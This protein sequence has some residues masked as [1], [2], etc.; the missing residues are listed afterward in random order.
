MFF[1]SIHL[2]RFFIAWKIY[3]VLYLMRWRFNLLSVLGICFSGSPPSSTG[4]ASGLVPPC[5]FE[6]IPC[7]SFPSIPLLLFQRGEPWSRYGIIILGVMTFTLFPYLEGQDWCWGT[8]APVSYA[9]EDKS[10]KFGHHPY[11]GNFDWFAPENYPLHLNAMVKH[12]I[13]A[14]CRDQQEDAP[15]CVETIAGWALR[16]S[17]AEI[18]PQTIMSIFYLNGVLVAFI[19]VYLHPSIPGR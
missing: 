13:L 9:S 1:S 11:S 3:P 18:T 6:C 14:T 7:A 12:T 4:H 16:H 15:R 10:S 2:A 19:L 5:W 8:F 17:V